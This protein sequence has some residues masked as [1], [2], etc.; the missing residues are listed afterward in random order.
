V[1]NPDPYTR[2]MRSK[3]KFPGPT[4]T[5]ESVAKVKTLHLWLGAPDAEMENS[6]KL[7]FDLAKSA[8]QELSVTFS[9]EAPVKEHPG[10]VRSGLS[11]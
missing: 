11:L 1:L 3:N 9:G 7:M 5:G 2:T 8:G 4:S 6:V 10:G